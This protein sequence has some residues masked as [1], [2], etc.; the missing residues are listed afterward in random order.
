MGQGDGAAVSKSHQMIDVLWQGRGVHGS[1]VLRAVVRGVRGQ[2]GLGVPLGLAVL[3]PLDQLHVPV[4]AMP[5]SRE[6]GGGLAQG[7]GI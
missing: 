4:P 1:R 6:G 2:D 7:L 3:Q 5:A